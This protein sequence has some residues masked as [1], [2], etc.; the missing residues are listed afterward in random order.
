MSNIKNKILI[1][2]DEP[3]IRKLLKIIYEDEN[4]Q[5]EEGENA[6]EAI[7]KALSGQYD[8]MILDLGLPDMDGKEVVKKIREISKM[9][10]IICS[11]RQ[12]DKEIIEA[13]TLGADDYITKPFNPEILIARTEAAL[14]RSVIEKS[15]SE[16]IT[17]GELS[18]NLLTHESFLSSTKIN[19]TPKEHMLLKYF[20]TN[21]DKVISHKQILTNIWGAANAEDLQYLRVYIRQLRDK[22]EPDT[23]KPCYI[24]NVPGVGYRM[25][26]FS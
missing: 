21:L 11:V 22:I 6:K 5:I 1:I 23:E 15:S 2:D 3:Q 9:P 20:L 24:I 18:M 14:R 10:I 7:R 8:V 25:P 19:L 4:Y 12:S 16:I 17:N 26:K 13:L